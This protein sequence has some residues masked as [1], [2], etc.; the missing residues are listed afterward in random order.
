MET[1]LRSRKR[2][3]VSVRKESYDR[4]TQLA[5]QRGTTR[6]ALVEQW[7]AEELDKKDANDGR[8]QQEAP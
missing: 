4:I 2:R 6:S 1:A 5:K 7:I 3:S 8:D